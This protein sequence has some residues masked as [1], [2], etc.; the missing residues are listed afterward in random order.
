[1]I[2]CSPI[3]NKGS[4]EMPKATQIKLEET[5]V[6]DIII[7]PNGIHNITVANTTNKDLVTI[8]LNQAPNVARMVDLTINVA[9]AILTFHRLLTTILKNKTEDR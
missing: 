9:L 7:S 3:R 2:L 1:V 8:Y 6:G 5:R 4:E